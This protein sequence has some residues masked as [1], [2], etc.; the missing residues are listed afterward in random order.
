MKKIILLGAALLAMTTSNAQTKAKDWNVGLHFGTQEYLGDL[1]NE[2]FTFQQHG[3]YGVSV[4]K[5]LTPFFDVQGMVTLSNLDFVNE[6]MNKEF[7]AR[8][9]DFNIMAKFKINNGKWLKENSLVQPFVVL[10][11][12]DGLTFADHYSNN[13]N[14]MSLDV[15]MLGGIGVNFAV[16]ERLGIN[17]MS[18]YTY[19]WTDELDNATSTDRNFQDQ[20]L[21]TSLGVTYNFS[22]KKDSDKDGVADEDDKCPNLAG[23]AANNGCPEIN[24]ET[25]EIMAN[26]MKGLFFETGSAVIKGESYAVLDNVANVMKSNNAYKLFV[27][28]HTDNTGD[29]ALNLKLSKER[30][31]AAKNYLVK[32]G[33]DASRITST[34]FGDS[35]PVA[36]NGT[37]EGR[38]QNRRVE[39]NIQF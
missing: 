10:G 34:G 24:N 32:K 39:F 17:V 1:G 13:S 11:F 22:T 23:T 33:V 4:S 27:S 31:T 7:E 16:S 26:A 9:V 15:N 36:D 6:D 21:M 14:N 3:A 19:M 38:K 30:A 29:Q 20:A 5:Y 35:Q 12:G 28:G 8:F 2:F 18:K 25:K 37:A